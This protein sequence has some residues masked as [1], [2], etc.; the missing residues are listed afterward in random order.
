MIKKF[1]LVLLMIF[2]ASC[3][4]GQS[5]ITSSKTDEKKSETQVVQRIRKPIEN[6]TQIIRSNKCIIRILEVLSSPRIGGL[7]G[8]LEKIRPQRVPLT[9]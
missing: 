5:V 7:L 2:V 8:L 3:N 9:E 4:A 1:I 6:R